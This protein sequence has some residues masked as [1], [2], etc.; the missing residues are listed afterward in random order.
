MWIQLLAGNMRY[1]V[2]E[3]P[4]ADFGIGIVRGSDIID[5]QMLM[6]GAPRSLKEII[7]AG[8][9]IGALSNPVASDPE[10]RAAA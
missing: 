3:A 4:S 1:A 10:T 9:Q 5:L 8:D 6:P 7:R 2:F